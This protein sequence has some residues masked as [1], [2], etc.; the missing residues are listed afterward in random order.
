V[1]PSIDD[2]RVEIKARAYNWAAV[3][4]AIAEDPA[5]VNVQP[6]G[7]WSALHQASEASRR[8][9]PYYDT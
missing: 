6:A 1:L 9:S 7:R 2:A 5:L 4:F 3:A 8:Q